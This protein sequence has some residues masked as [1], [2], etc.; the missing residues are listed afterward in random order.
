M[1][2]AARTGNAISVQSGNGTMTLKYL[3]GA[4]WLAASPLAWAQAPGQPAAV[5]TQGAAKPTGDQLKQAVDQRIAMLK[6]RLAITPAQADAWN[7][8]AQTMRDNAASTNQLFQNR[9]QNAASMSAVDNM[10]SYAAIAKAYADNTQKLADAF[11]TLYG[12]LSPEQQKTAD[13]LFRQ[14]PA[15]GRK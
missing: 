9:A 11:S 4:A 2:A 12:K 6:T 8:F 5:A 15:P 3:L 10:K 7:A 14:P 13:Q 1:P